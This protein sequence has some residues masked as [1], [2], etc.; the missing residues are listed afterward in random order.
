MQFERDE[1]EL[2]Q[3]HMGNNACYF[4]NTF[5]VPRS[6][7]FF[8][9]E[10]SQLLKGEK[11]I[12]LGNLILQA[13]INNEKFQMYTSIKTYLL[14]IYY[15]QNT[16]LKKASMTE[17]QS[18]HCSPTFRGGNANFIIVFLSPNTFPKYMRQ[19]IS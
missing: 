8:E 15:V 12:A 13:H 3:I 16:V 19:L 17:R 7:F 11:E 6:I 1:N 2:A 18:P 10:R 5:L 14:R 9:E 4:C